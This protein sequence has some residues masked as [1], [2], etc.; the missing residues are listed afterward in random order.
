MVHIGV[1]HKGAKEAPIM[2]DISLV[3]CPDCGSHIPYAFALIAHDGVKTA[4]MLVAKCHKCAE[5]GDHRSVR[6]F[7]KASE[8]AIRSMCSKKIPVIVLGG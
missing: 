7:K 8:G 5:A 4:F 6:S 3:G 2:A 1:H